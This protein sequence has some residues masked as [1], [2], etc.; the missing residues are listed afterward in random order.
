MQP[1][2]LLSAFAFAVLNLPVVHATLD[3]QG[4]LVKLRF[5]RLKNLLLHR[6]RRHKSNCK[7]LAFLSYSVRPG[8]TQQPA[9]RRPF[10]Y[11]A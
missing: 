6:V 5:G 10:V 11:R 8:N 2:P 4:V 7:N 3:D 9:G 1:A